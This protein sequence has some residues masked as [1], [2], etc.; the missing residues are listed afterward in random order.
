MPTVDDPFAKASRSLIQAVDA[1]TLRVLLMLATYA[2]FSTGKNAYPSIETLMADLGVKSRTTIKHALR[3]G[4]RK[5]LL[6]R[7]PRSAKD[8]GDT[9]ASYDCLWISRDCQNIDRGQAKYLTGAGAEDCPQPRSHD[10]DPMTQISTHTPL[11]GSDVNRFRKQA[12]AL[13]DLYHQRCPNAKR[14]ALPTDFI[15]PQIVKA[16]AMGRTHRAWHLYFDKVH[17]SDKLSPPNGADEYQTDLIY[18][19]EPQNIA[20]IEAGRFDNPT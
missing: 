14:Y 5:G 8:G 13:V 16:L 9:S 1:P 11:R 15:P 19:L 17:D 10:P 12:Q 3:V 2:D 4:E 20:K 6:R 7:V 18:V